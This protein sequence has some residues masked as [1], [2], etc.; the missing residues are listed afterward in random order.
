MLLMPL[1]P[2]RTVWATVLMLTVAVV[3]MAT[4][5]YWG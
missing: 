4:A 1:R 2:E 5:R 3:T